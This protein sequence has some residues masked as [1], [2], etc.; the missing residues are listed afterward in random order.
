VIE[1]FNTKRKKIEWNRKQTGRRA[2]PDTPLPWK[3]VKKKK[4]GCRTISFSKKQ[5]FQGEKNKQVTRK[6]RGRDGRQ[7][8]SFTPKIPGKKKTKVPPKKLREVKLPPEI[9]DK[10]GPQRT[11][12]SPFFP[13]NGKGGGKGN[14]CQVKVSKKREESSTPPSKKRD[15]SHIQRSTSKKTGG[16]SNGNKILCPREGRGELIKWSLQPPNWDKNGRKAIPEPLT[17]GKKPLEQELKLEK[18]TPRVF[19]EA[20][21]RKKTLQPRTP[22]QGRDH[23]NLI[24]GYT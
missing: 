4:Q 14:F 3:R 7:T 2:P 22:K 10:R 23:L 11:T 8:E 5:V 13:P 24:A 17:K 1:K 12:V 9:Q 19:N 18:R 21:R 20:R 16:D 6:H 15:K